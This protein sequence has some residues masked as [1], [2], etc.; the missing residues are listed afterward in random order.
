M[1]IKYLDKVKNEYKFDDIIFRDTELNETQLIKIER[2]ILKESNYEKII[3]NGMNIIDFGSNLLLL[4]FEENN[5]EEYKHLLNQNFEMVGFYAKELE[6]KRQNPKYKG[7]FEYNGKHYIMIDG[8]NKLTDEINPDIGIYKGVIVNPE[9]YLKVNQ[10]VK[11]TSGKI[12]DL[13]K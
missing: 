3:F 10:S 13:I 11:E 9:M 6:N 8:L 12:E 1:E 2:Y 7:F 5:I 4:E